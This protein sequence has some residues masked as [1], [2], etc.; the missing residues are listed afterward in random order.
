MPDLACQA[1]RACSGAGSSKLVAGFCLACHTANSNTAQL[2]QYAQQSGRH[3]SPVCD[4]SV[5]QGCNPAAVALAGTALALA[6]PSFGC[7]LAC[8]TVSINGATVTDLDWTSHPCRPSNLHCQPG[9]FCSGAGSPGP[10]VGCGLASCTSRQQHKRWWTDPNRFLICAG[11]QTFISSLAGPAVAL[12]AQGH[13]LAVVWH[14]APPG[15]N[16]DQLLQYA[17]H[18][19]TEQQQVAG[20]VPGFISAHHVV[21]QGLLVCAKAGRHVHVILLMSMAHSAGQAA[22]LQHILMLRQLAGMHGVQ[23]V[24]ETGMHGALQAVHDTGMHG[25]LQA[26]H[27][28]GM[29]LFTILCTHPHEKA[30]LHA[31]FDA[32]LCLE[33]NIHCLWLV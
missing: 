26:V 27:E 29:H 18:D 23:A 19:V 11:L 8:H 6:A 25:A 3:W 30:L 20:P 1:G 31:A 13:L 33:L 9:R 22:Q 4:F 16:A 21:S 5:L 7:C 28:T 24:H 17:V 2:L 32:P 14:A 10:S 15:S 12:A